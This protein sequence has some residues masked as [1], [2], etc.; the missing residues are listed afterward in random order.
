[1]T[2]PLRPKDPQPLNY[3]PPGGRRMPFIEQMALGFGALVGTGAGVLAIE[4]ILASNGLEGPE[5]RMAV[6][7]LGVGFLVVLA[8]VALIRWRWP[9]LIAG[10]F[11]GLLIFGLIIGGLAL[12]IAS[13]CGS[14]R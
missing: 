10:I 8:L 12:L 14:S 2:Q 6:I 5:V 1:M 13:M 9:G 11:T 3:A 7:G 4:Y